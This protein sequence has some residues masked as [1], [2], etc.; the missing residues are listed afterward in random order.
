MN[1]AIEQAL[2]SQMHPDIVKGLD[3]GTSD[4]ARRFF[5]VDFEG[6]QPITVCVGTWNLMMYAK[7]I[8]HKGFSNNPFLVEEIQEQY[9]A[10]KYLQ[11]NIIL[12]EVLG[13]KLDVFFLQEA[14]F[15][16]PNPKD[17][18]GIAY[19]KQSLHQHL[20]GVLNLL[21]FAIKVTRPFQV[22]NFGTNP[23]QPLV[24][25]YNTRSL[26]LEPNK[27]DIGGL[28]N[29]RLQYRCSKSYFIHIPSGKKIVLM[30]AHLD[31]GKDYSN[32]DCL[33]S[34]LIAESSANIFLIGGG[35]MNHCPGSSMPHLI[36]DKRPSTVGAVMNI[37]EYAR[38]EL[39]KT[40]LTTAHAQT[41]SSMAYDGLFV[42]PVASYRAKVT[43]TGGEY[44]EL[45]TGN[46]VAKFKPFPIHHKVYYSHFGQT[47]KNEKY[48]IQA[49]D[50]K[51]GNS[52]EDPNFNQ[53]TFLLNLRAARKG[54]EP[55]K[56]KKNLPHYS[57]LC[58]PPPVQ[59]AQLPVTQPVAHY[60]NAKNKNSCAPD[61]PQSAKD[62]ILAL[63]KK[64]GFSPM[65]LEIKLDDKDRPIIKVHFKLRKDA[66]NFGRDIGELAS[67]CDRDSVVAMSAQCANKQLFKWEGL[68]AQPN[69]HWL[70]CQ[71]TEEHKSIVLKL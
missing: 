9:H 25:I 66:D 37:T 48:Q 58:A 71:L 52:K 54:K 3:G 1:P 34:S 11:V 5:R 2:K 40:I 35:D 36:T 13:R 12:E 32:S 30:N 59:Q 64:K 62:Q 26:Q 19:V 70:Y 67:T 65:R 7:K 47:Y 68:P 31:Y 60:R 28:P 51:L 21:G 17:E 20:Q 49:L 56:L 38:N 50:K 55:T 69:T 29:D 53:I 46:N 45:D 16:F 14:D 22:G 23:Q 44:I 33:H 42:T 24:T 61:K 6:E 41:E 27:I 15:M 4:H 63:I 39:N 43:L 8:N 18:P 57:A 10:R